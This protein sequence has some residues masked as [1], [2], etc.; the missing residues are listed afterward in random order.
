M[1]VRGVDNYFSGVITETVSDM[2]FTPNTPRYAVNAGSASQVTVP[3]GG[4][5]DLTVSAVAGGD[6]ASPSQSGFLFLER[7]ALQP[8][9]TETVTVT[10]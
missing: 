4:A 10:P 6:T 9:E 1:D 8:E 7:L 5:I 2:V 3:A